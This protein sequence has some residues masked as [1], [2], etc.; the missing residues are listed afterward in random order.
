MATHCHRKELFKPQRE[1]DVASA[2]G[3]HVRKRFSESCDSTFRVCCKVF[4]GLICDVESASTQASF[5]TLGLIHHLGIKSRAS[6]EMPQI[7]DS[8]K[9]IP[10]ESL[11]S[12]D[13]YC[14]KDVRL[15]QPVALCIETSRELIDLIFSRSILGV[16]S[17]FLI[18][19]FNPVILIE[20]FV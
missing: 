12:S 3:F 5:Y 11:S 4:L 16:E 7:I 1:R 17:G 9:Q 10:M 6:K 15:E 8:T 2:H 19:I 14:R 13:R 20:S 18:F